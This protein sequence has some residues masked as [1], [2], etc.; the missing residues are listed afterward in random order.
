MLELIFKNHFADGVVFVTA[1]FVKGVL[2]SLFFVIA[3]NHSLGFNLILTG[4]FDAIFTVFGLNSKFF[5]TV[6]VHLELLVT[7]LI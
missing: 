1:L 7:K 4:Y 6:G 2:G 3:E 5:Y